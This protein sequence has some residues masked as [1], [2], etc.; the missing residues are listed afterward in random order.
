MQGKLDGGD[1]LA[2][3]FFMLG[4]MTQLGF[5]N[6]ENFPFVNPADAIH[7]FS[8]GGE[9]VTISIAIGL[10]LLALVVAFITN[11]QSFSAMGGMQLFLVIVTVGLI[12]SPPFMPILA[13][14]LTADIAG[15][16]ALFLQTIG[17]LQVSWTG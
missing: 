11:D 16:V 7:T 13:E 12:I 3:L 17:Y 4:G 2:G 8:Y 15:L 6:G 9:S 10:S 1:M 5:I 14:A